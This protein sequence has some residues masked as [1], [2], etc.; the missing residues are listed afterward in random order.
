MFRDK[1][2]QILKVI[3]TEQDTNS[4]YVDDNSRTNV[5]GLEID[6]EEEEV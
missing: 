2:N 4:T 5:R 1:Q 6:T 3:Y